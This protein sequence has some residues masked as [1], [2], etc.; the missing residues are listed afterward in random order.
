[1]HAGHDGNV[2]RKDNGSWQNWSNGGWNNVDKPAQG[3]SGR[4]GEAGAGTRDWSSTS[5]QLNRDF[6][7]RQEG[8]ARTRDFGSI[9]E[10]A[11][12]SGRRELSPRRRWR[13]RRRG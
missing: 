13:R 4:V 1:M 2:Y 8:A 10:R 9:S 6:G 3:T 7:A 11:D 12:A 5:G